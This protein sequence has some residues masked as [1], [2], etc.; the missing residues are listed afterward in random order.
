M[1]YFST[2]RLLMKGPGAE[3]MWQSDDPQLLS[4][5]RLPV[6]PVLDHQ[7]DVL[8]IDYMRELRAVLMEQLTDLF[9]GESKTSRWYEMYLTVFLLLLALEML[10]HHQ[11]QYERQWVGHVSLTSSLIIFT[12]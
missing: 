3:G 4:Q 11:L 12:T 1:A 2:L 8:S 7:I 10:H 6:P 5:G 9:H